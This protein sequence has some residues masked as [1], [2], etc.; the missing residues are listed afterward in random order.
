MGMS[1][2]DKF[3]AYLERFYSRLPDSPKRGF[4]LKVL[5]TSRPYDRIERGFSKL[6]KIIPTIRLAGEEE[7]DKISHEIGL[8]IEAM[9]KDIAEKRGLQE[10]QRSVLQRRLGEIPN[11]TYL[12]LYLTLNEVEKGLGKTLKKLLKIIDTLPATVEEAYEKILVRGV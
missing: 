9:V 6:T 2:R 8:A 5:I 11:R 4:R 1:G 10:E 12:W 7:S 3:I